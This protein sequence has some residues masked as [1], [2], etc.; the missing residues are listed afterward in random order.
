LVALEIY[1]STAPLNMNNG[2]KVSLGMETN[3]STPAH[4]L[5]EQTGQQRGLILVID[6]LAE[7]N[8]LAQLFIANVMHDY[9][10]LYQ[11]SEL[12][13]LAEFGPWLVRL[14]PTHI[15]DI[16]TLLDNPQQDWGW[17]ASFKDADLKQIAQHWRER[18]VIVENGQRSLYRF[19]DNR[20]IAQD[21]PA[22]NEQ[23]LPLLLGPLCSALY[24]DEQ[25]WLSTDNPRPADCPPPFATPWVDLPE[26]ESILSENARQNLEGWLWE[27]HSGATLRLSETQGLVPWL[28]QQ[29]AHA[30]QWRWTSLESVQFLLEHRLNPDRA[31]HP[32]WAVQAGE[33]PDMH[34]ARCGE[35]FTSG[36]LE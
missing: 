7:S 15:T 4:W 14:D 8:P 26:R 5:S 9:V 31:Q 29:L 6:R 20:V 27:S 13:E 34:F 12:S 30:K 36:R 25:R 33:S 3:V 10:N 21:L 24:W 2:I 19:Q 28:E 11:D 17:L 35:T 32:D 1:M 23:Q 18:M 16:K 22:L